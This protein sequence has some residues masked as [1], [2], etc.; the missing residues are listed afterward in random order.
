MRNAIRFLL[1]TL[2][3]VIA[4]CS[5]GDQTLADGG[6]T[7]TETEA[8]IV[9]KIV[10]PDGE[11][12][13]GAHVIIHKQAALSGRDTAI[14]QTTTDDQGSFSVIVDREETY[15]VEANYVGASGVKKG[16]VFSVD[17]GDFPAYDLGNTTL[18]ALGSIEVWMSCD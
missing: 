3:S 6:G 11:P 1:L 13:A 16:V 17:V 12:A 2:L 14:A 7:A 15:I 5:L 9:A 10:T 4:A 8:T 18:K